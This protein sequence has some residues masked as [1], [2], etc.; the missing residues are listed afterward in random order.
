MTTYKFDKLM[1]E[2]KNFGNWRKELWK[3]VIVILGAFFVAAGFALF[4]NPYQIIPGGVFGLGRVFHHLIPSIPTGTFGLMMD[5]PLLITAFIVFGRGFGTKTILAALSTPI[6]MNALTRFVGEDPLD[7]KSLL[8]LYFNFSDNVLVAAIFGGLFIGGGIGLLLKVGATSGGTDIVDM[9][10]VKYTKLPFSVAMLIVESTIVITGMLVLGDWKLPLYSLIAIFVSSKTIDFTLE[11]VK[12]D[13]LLF[14]ISDKEEQIRN[15]ILNDL[16]RGATCI[17]AQGAYTL[18]DK[19]ML[20]LA[21]RRA[22]V[23][24]VKENIRK[25][26]SK[27]FM[28]VVDSY[29]TYGDGFTPFE[30]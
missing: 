13:K 2:I 19:N 27:A 17:K 9:L 7:G 3:W 21:V 20:F 25:I 30:K 6:I 29:E 8:S 26:D 14:I 23:P 11:G 24:E 4:T 16:Q 12:N 10:V 1:K 28:V 15:F 22:E 5:I 18:K